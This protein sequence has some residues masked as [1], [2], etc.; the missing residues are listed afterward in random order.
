[1]QTRARLSTWM[2]CLLAAIVVI[3]LFSWLAYRSAEQ[4]R[5]NGLLVEKAYEGDLNA[6][7]RALKQGADPNAMDEQWVP[8]D[9]FSRL[10]SYFSSATKGP[11]TALM[12]AS[13]AGHVEVVRVLLDRGADVNARGDAQHTALMDA[14]KNGRI[15]V[16]RLLISRGADVNA[17]NIYGTS[18]LG[19]LRW[20]MPQKQQEMRTILVKAG[21]HE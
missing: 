18:T 15:E 13:I 3:S 19:Y 17:K 20:C 8:P 10:K 2:S 1:M 16:V 9:A 4:K 14:M 11:T 21:A 7:S 12:R 6:V 5:L